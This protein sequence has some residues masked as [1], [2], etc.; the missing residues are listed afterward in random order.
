MHKNDRLAVTYYS[1]YS[2]AGNP[3]SLFV[4]PAKCVWRPKWPPA[5]GVSW[6]CQP[7]LATFGKELIRR[8]RHAGA[9]FGDL[10]RRVRPQG[11]FATGMLFWGIVGV[12]VQSLCSVRVRNIFL[13]LIKCRRSAN[14]I[15][16]AQ[17]FLD[18]LFLGS[19]SDPEALKRD[20]RRCARWPCST[21]AV[22]IG[23]WLGNLN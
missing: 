15:Q 3:I 11:L 12:P 19:Y 22:V 2:D 13:A 14:F 7:G 23:Q 8:R 4:W 9:T 6:S 17:V 16:P 21:R 18:G 5:R 10:P 20:D 1:E